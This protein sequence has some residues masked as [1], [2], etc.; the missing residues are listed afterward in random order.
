MRRIGAG[1][2]EILK[3][4]K[5]NVKGI[6]EKN[7]ETI[8]EM[9]Y[10]K[11]KNV[12]DYFL[13]EYL[14]ADSKRKEKEIKKAI[15]WAN[16]VKEITPMWLFEF[17]TIIGKTINIQPA[18][19]NYA[20]MVIGDIRLHAMNEHPGLRLTMEYRPDGYTTIETPHDIGE[21][22]ARWKTK[23]KGDDENSNNNP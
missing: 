14:D 16:T 5:R 21:I 18:T 8:T 7:T 23:K 19:S 13:D 1:E 11:D 15:Q 20:V 12:S 6:L 22:V 17:V 2:K 9:M 4:L 10:M 3:K